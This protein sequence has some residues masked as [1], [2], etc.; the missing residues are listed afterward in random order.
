MDWYPKVKK[1]MRYNVE[2]LINQVI[3]QWFIRKGF[4]CPIKHFIAANALG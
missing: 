3:L 2:K 4:L 1:A